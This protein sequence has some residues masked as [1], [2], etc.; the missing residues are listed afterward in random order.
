M[1]R[2]GKLR[3][4]S[5]ENLAGHQMK[6]V[7][8][9]GSRETMAAHR[10]RGQDGPGIRGGIVGFESAKDGHGL[11][12][13]RLPSGDVYFAAVCAARHS[14]ARV[15]HTLAERAPLVERRIIYLDDVG[16]APHRDESRTNPSTDDI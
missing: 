1:V 2:A 9:K 5:I 11:C 3:S 12:T 14:A 13:L 15:R 16:I 4:L 7:P 8:E 10:H 6:P